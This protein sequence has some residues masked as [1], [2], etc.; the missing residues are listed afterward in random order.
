MAKKATK[1][2]KKTEKRD[3]GPSTTVQFRAEAT[4]YLRELEAMIEKELG[5][6]LQP[7]Q[8]VTIALKNEVARRKE[9]S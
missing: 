2:K 3:R 9:E 1:I 6:T 5:I 7:S 4:G 8:V